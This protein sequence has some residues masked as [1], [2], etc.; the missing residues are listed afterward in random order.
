MTVVQVARKL[1]S[2]AKEDID[3][4]LDSDNYLNEFAA[5][6]SILVCLGA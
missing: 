4:G 2:P 3:E 1:F 6:N 5:Y